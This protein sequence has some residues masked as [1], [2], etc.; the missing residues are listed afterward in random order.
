MI[1]R[2]YQ[3]TACASLIYGSQLLLALEDV[4]AAQQRS[5]VDEIDSALRNPHNQPREGLCRNETLGLL[6]L[7][8][9]G[10]IDVW[11]RFHCGDRSVWRSIFTVVRWY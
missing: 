7:A 3:L 5:S 9:A 10:K 11:H 4:V 1:L 6:W 2:F 8:L